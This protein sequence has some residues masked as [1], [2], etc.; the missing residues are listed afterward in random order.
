MASRSVSV[1]V[2]GQNY[3]ISASVEDDE[4]QRLAA[5][6]DDKIMALTPTGR[7]VS[8]QAIL[9]AA[10]ALAHEAEEQRER[11]DALAERTQDLCDR[12]L[13][14]VDE[15]LG[16]LEDDAPAGLPHEHSATAP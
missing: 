12:I 1:R 14:R 16:P 9:L 3:R 7:P 6:V 2:G 10:I 15:V 11:A 13:A 5:V 4:L 8:P